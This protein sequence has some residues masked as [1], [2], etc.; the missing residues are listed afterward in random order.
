MTEKCAGR[1]IVSRVVVV[2]A[3]LG[4]LW[5][6][7]M[8]SATLWAD[9]WVYR[10]E[11][12][13]PVVRRT[14]NTVTLRWHRYSRWVMEGRCAREVI[15]DIGSDTLPVTTPVME[16]GWKVFDWE[17]PI[18]LHA[19]GSCQIHG[20]MQY[21]PLGKFGPKLTYYWKSEAF[22]AQQP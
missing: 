7:V 13:L 8:S 22:L 6:I 19:Q 9:G 18:P 5:V 4:C 14:E 10:V 2:M 12:P 1:G 16:P 21:E 11:Q 17:Y 20:V 3:A 15:C